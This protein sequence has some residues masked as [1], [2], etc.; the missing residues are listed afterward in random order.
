MQV[1]TSSQHCSSFRQEV[2]SSDTSGGTTVTHPQTSWIPRQPGPGNPSWLST[3][4]ITIPEE[5]EPVLSVNNPGDSGIAG[6]GPASVS[7]E[8][9]FPESGVAK[10][11]AV[12]K[13]KK[14]GKKSEK[15]QETAIAI[16][17]ETSLVL[18]ISSQSDFRIEKT[19]PVPMPS[20]FLHLEQ[21]LDKISTL[22][23]SDNFAE[24]KENAITIVRT[25]P[26]LSLIHI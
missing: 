3:Y 16:S 20:E 17:E 12:K 1:T 11:S 6:A 7:D 9:G 8:P 13:K 25:L 5:T 18:S 10:T 2:H 14:S 22:Y 24:A 19:R 23:K 21:D 4:N 15:S 26:D